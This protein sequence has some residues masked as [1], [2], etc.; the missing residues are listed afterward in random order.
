[1]LNLPHFLYHDECVI[2]RSQIRSGRRPMVNRRVSSFTGPS[3][4]VTILDYP[5]PPPCSGYQR[6]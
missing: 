6:G 5:P 1:M 3:A 2:P 4:G